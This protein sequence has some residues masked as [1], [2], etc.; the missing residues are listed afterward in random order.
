VIWLQEE[1]LTSLSEVCTGNQFNYKR[2]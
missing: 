2:Y 1:N